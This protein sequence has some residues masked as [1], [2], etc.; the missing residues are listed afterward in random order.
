MEKYTRQS[1][2]LATELT[3]RYST[4][5]STSARLFDAR[6]RPGIFAIYGMTRLAD[7]IVDSYRGPDAAQQLTTF[8]AAVYQA[9]DA[10]FSTNP[11]LH[12]FA[13]TART[14]G[15]GRDLI[16]P[17][18]ASMGM[19][20]EPGNY[21]TDAYQTY[22]Y[23][24]AEVI[25]LM[26]LRVFVD[27]DE[28]A[29]SARQAGARALGSAYQKV[30]FLRDIKQ[31]YD[32][33]GRMYFPGVTYENFSE[34]DKAAIVADIATDF[35]RARADIDHLPAGARRAVAT[36]YAYYYELFEVLQNTPVS[37]ITSRRVRVPDWKKAWLLAR[38]MVRR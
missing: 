17:F 36:S 9:I 8:Q 2:H 27:G 6:I 7:E 23:G 1:Y 22:I 35:E 25:G 16:E 21:D 32:E 31:D 30:N 24:S 28:T 33:L 18:F 19:D 15:I 4:S 37:E 26:C 5:F 20:I 11:L 29:Y 10:E 14:Y 3:R 34:S 13:D 12:A 38:Q